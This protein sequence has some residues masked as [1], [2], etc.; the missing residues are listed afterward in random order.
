MNLLNKE[1]LPEG[2][3]YPDE[4][5][6][7]VNLQL[8]DLEPW[9]IME[10]DYLF[11]RYQGLKERYPEKKLIPFC[12]RLDN[13]DIACWDMDKGDSVIIIHDFSSNGW[14]ER[15]AFPTFWNWFRAAIEDMINW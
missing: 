9:S 4:F 15:G 1:Q 7:I 10:G 13:D 11:K 6:K 8:V 3:E 14:E 2:F 12:R 5:L